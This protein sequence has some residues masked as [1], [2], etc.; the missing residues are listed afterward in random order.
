M[1]Q[2]VWAHGDTNLSIDTTV[3]SHDIPVP[4]PGMIIYIGFN[5]VFGKMGT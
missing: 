5:K 1:Q 4:V 3:V 2:A